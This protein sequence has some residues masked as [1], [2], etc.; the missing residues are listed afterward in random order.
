L[1]RARQALLLAGEL[2]AARAQLQEALQVANELA[3]R[4]YQPQLWL[5][6]AAIARAQGRAETGAAAARRA[7]EEARAQEAHWLELLALVDLREH[8]DAAAAER[9]AL[10]AL[11]DRLPEAGDTVAVRRARAILQPVK[12]A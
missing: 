8:H 3:E 2:D 4:V 9:S 12:S 10:A 5:L 1:V 6:Q 11:V 7:I